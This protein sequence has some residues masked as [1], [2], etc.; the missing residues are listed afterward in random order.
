MWILL[1]LIKGT[2]EIFRRAENIIN[3][4]NTNWVAVCGDGNCF[5]RSMLISAHA[6]YTNKDVF[7]LRSDYVASLRRDLGTADAQR[8]C[9]ELWPT[10]LYMLTLDDYDHHAKFHKSLPVTG[11]GSAEFDIPAMFA[12]WDSVKSNFS[13]CSLLSPEAL[14]INGKSIGAG[15]PM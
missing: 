1:I 6:G 15:E 2:L 7:Q 10:T 5:F 12:D 11:W 14:V 3:D 4:L 9:L 8:R 13:P